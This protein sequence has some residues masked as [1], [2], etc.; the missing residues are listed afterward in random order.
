MPVH[1]SLLPRGICSILTF[2][3]RILTNTQ[4]N[5]S[6][7]LLWML[8]KFP[9]YV[10]YVKTATFIT[11]LFSDRPKI[12]T[13]CCLVWILCYVK[14]NR[15]RERNWQ[16]ERTLCGRLYNYIKQFILRESWKCGFWKITIAHI[17]VSAICPSQFMILLLYPTQLLPLKTKDLF[18]THIPGLIFYFKSNW[19]TWHKKT[20]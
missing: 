6:F 7:Q 9:V 1:L 20:L 2:T 16:T 3:T 12:S 13:L 17:H 15:K 18:Q 14:S 19:R 10:N 5:V 11:T 4:L 8:L